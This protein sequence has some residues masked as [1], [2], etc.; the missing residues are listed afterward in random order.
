MKFV[1]EN[2]C[3]IPT[4]TQTEIQGLLGRLSD[5]K[6]KETS[7][8]RLTS[9]INSLAKP[10]QPLPVSPEEKRKE[11]IKLFIH[12]IGKTEDEYK[13]LLKKFIETTT[14]KERVSI[15]MESIQKL[16]FYQLYTLAFKFEELQISDAEKRQDLAKLIVDNS[17]TT[18]IEKLYSQI[19][20]ISEEE[21]GTV[22]KKAAAYF[23]SEE[24]RFE[25]CKLL[26]NEY[27][28]DVCRHINEFNLAKEHR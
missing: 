14:E 4:Q 7:C 25:M 11:S 1:K 23:P 17:G 19:T 24:I 5:A 21:L 2:A 3:A 28:T 13:T 10:F 18:I 8:Q 27:S 26:I 6:T 9:I 22:V 20:Y 12:L 15:M 16:K